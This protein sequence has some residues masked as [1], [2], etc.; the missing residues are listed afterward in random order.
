MILTHLDI[1]WLG[2]DQTFW[3]HCSKCLKSCRK[4]KG[5]ST[6]CYLNFSLIGCRVNKGHPRLP[7]QTFSA[8]R[9][10]PSIATVGFGTS[11]SDTL[12]TAAVALEEILGWYADHFIVSLI[13]SRRHRNLY[14]G[15]VQN[16]MHTW[17]SLAKIFARWDAILSEKLRGHTFLGSSAVR[18]WAVCDARPAK[19]RNGAKY[20]RPSRCSKFLLEEFQYCEWLFEMFDVNWES[21]E[22][23]TY[24]PPPATRCSLREVCYS[25]PLLWYKPSAEQRHI[26]NV[27]RQYYLPSLCAIAHISKCVH[28]CVTEHTGYWEA[29]KVNDT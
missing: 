20:H 12:I 23:F 6:S 10:N 29:L 27:W 14:E 5:L 2:P 19:P 17:L 4:R 21:S 13:L 16:K 18:S 15:L 9:L 3:V 1:L 26:L 28:Q 7:R 22:R 25:I 8:I 24:T 11:K